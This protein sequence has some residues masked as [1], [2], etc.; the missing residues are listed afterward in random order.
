M[1][2]LFNS[3]V[4]DVATGLIFVYLLLAVICSAINERISSWFSLRAEN[5]EQAIRQL[6]DNQGGGDQQGAA[7]ED[8]DW[9]LKQFKGHPLIAGMYKPGAGG[10]GHPSYVPSRTFATVVMDIATQSVALPEAAAAGAGAQGAAT[11]KQNGSITFQDLEA[12]IQKLPGGD[13][14]TALLALI[15][16]ADEDLTTA[17]K[18]IETWFDDTM[19]RMGGWYKRKVQIIT[20]LV[21][22]VLVVGANADTLRMTT[23]LWRNPTQRAQLVEAAKQR[24]GTATQEANKTDL[25]QLDG[26]VGWGSTGTTAPEPGNCW[27]LWAK[28]LGGWFL[29]IVAVSLGAPFWFDLLNKIVNLR[30][31][32]AKPKTAQQNSA[33]E[34][35]ATT[36]AAAGAAP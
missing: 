27:E 1:N 35:Q 18:N 26:L 13:V 21:A 20:F 34:A 22:I 25:Q 28:R 11:P 10:G 6:L 2:G 33:E 9:F 15:Q 3:N 24:A 36:A 16:N 12:G 7:N 4:L 32:G 31:A 17:Q 23:I 29:T 19:D 8:L 30:S 5:L 14:K